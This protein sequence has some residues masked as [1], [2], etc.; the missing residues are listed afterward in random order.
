MKYWIVLALPLLFMACKTKKIVPG[1]EEISLYVMLKQDVSPKTIKEDL[2]F[3]VN[4]YRKASDIANQWLF[5]FIEE[6][7]KENQIRA[8]LLNHSQVI[9]VFDQEQFAKIKAKKESGGKDGITGK[10][11]LKQ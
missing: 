8:E 5:K 4:S 7:S 3:D 6:K 2:S 1:S 9:S 10:K 11:V